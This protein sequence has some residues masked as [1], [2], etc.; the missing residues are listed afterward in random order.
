M[1]EKVSLFRG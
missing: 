1:G